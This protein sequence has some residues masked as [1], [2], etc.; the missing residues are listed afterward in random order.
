MHSTNY[1]LAFVMTMTVGVALVLALLSSSWKAKSKENEAIFNKRAIL[2][3]V[4]DH[5]G[6]MDPKTM[7]DE[8]VLEIFGQNV[9][10][11]ALNMDGQEIDAAAVEA[12]GHK[13]GMAENIDMKKEK[14]KPE[15][16]RIRPLFVYKKDGKEFYILS[17]RGNGLWDEIWGYVALESDWNTVA[18]AAFDHQGETP[19]LGAEIKDNTSWAAQFK[20]E[21]IFDNQ[22]NYVSIAVV[23]GG[24]APSNPHAVDG[25]SGATVTANGVGE[26]LE[27]GLKYYLPY[28]NKVDDSKK[29]SLN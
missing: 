15:A 17:I 20:G 14:K 7:S 21:K 4:K 23:K 22:G 18:G 2:A 10:Q 13:G 19:G 9:T 3:A 6:G 5:L 28:I 16:E 29:L 26:M 1:V 8:E 25:I 11:M 27:R 12:A 24:A